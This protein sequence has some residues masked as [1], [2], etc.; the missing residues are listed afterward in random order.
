MNIAK[1]IALDMNVKPT[2]PTKRLTVDMAITSL[3]SKFEQLK[4]FES[5]FGFLFNSNKLKSLN[6]KKLRECCVT[7]YSTFS[8]EFFLTIPVI[9]AL[10]ERKFFKAKKDFLENIDVDV[11]INDFA[12][13]NALDDI[14][15]D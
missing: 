1:S 7:F 13:R 8:Y 15:V 9:M 2:L 3:K 11:I 4:T 12:S 14:I 5:I 6:E 10:I